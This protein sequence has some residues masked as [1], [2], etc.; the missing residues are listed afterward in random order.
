MQ[1]PFVQDPPSSQ[2]FP[3]NASVNPLSEAQRSHILLFTV[4]K[5]ACMPLFYAHVA[6]VASLGS[7]TD[8]PLPQE[9]QWGIPRATKSY[10]PLAEPPADTVP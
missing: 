2:D 1:G 7:I 5:H 4:A 10:D 3:D 8:F 6:V 9:T